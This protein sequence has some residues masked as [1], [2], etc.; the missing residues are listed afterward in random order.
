MSPKRRG[1]G[2]WEIHGTGTAW[3][4]TWACLPFQTPACPNRS[5]TKDGTNP[6]T[7][8]P[9]DVARTRIDGIPAKDV[10]TIPSPIPQPHVP[11][12]PTPS[13]RA[14][15]QVPRRWTETC[16]TTGTHRGGTEATEKWSPKG[17][18]F[19]PPPLQMHFRTDAPHSID[20]TQ[21]LRREGGE[22]R[23]GTEL[24]CKKR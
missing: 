12:R 3:T 6:R 18:N 16:T 23:R 4:G 8:P 1:G 9:P 10:D 17:L 22:T 14:N 2:R 20:L 19:G 11:T 7:Q 21:C 13:T 5:P 15:E 24:P